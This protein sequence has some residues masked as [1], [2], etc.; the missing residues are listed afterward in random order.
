MKSRVI[1]IELLRVKG[2]TIRTKDPLVLTPEQWRTFL[3]CLTHEPARTMAIVDMCLGIR[4]GEL[5]GLK[6][7]DFDWEKR[8]A[9]IQRS[10]V[11]NT[12]DSVKTPRSKALMPL[13]PELV[14]VLQRWRIASEFKRD[15]D[16]VWASPW[17]AGEWS[18]KPDAMLRDWVQPTAERAGSP[19]FG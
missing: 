18:L 2:A 9:F 15:D 12:V 6:W 19:R 1:P 13:D 16:W 3:E 17:R 5:R 8:T 11:D 7:S 4:R 14:T 10:L